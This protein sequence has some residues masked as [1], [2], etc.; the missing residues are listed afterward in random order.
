MRVQFSYVQSTAMK[1]S[2]QLL[3]VLILKL[4]LSW[5]NTDIIENNN[6]LSLK[7]LNVLPQNDNN[8]Y[9]PL[10]ITY[11]LYM[12]LNGAGGQ[13]RTELLDLLGIDQQGIIKM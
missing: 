7:L 6:R 8:F 10:S 5:V 2:N 4:F 9:S 11:S 13:T 1:R 12:L 3:F